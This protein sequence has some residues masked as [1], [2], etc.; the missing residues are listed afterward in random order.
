MENEFKIV[1]FEEF[2]PNCKWFKESEESE[3]C[4][5]CLEICA[6]ENSFRPEKYEEK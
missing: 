2:C 3:K 4:S 1:K 6:R 5:V